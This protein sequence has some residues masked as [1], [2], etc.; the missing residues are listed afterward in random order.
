MI[1]PRMYRSRTQRNPKQ[2]KKPRNTPSLPL[3]SSSKTYSRAGRL[4]ALEEKLVEQSD[5]VFWAGDGVADGA[6]VHEDLV[7]VTTCARLSIKEEQGG[8]AG[9]GRMDRVG[10]TEDG[11]GGMNQEGRVESAGG[12]LGRSRRKVPREGKEGKRNKT[13]KTKIRSALGFCIYLL[14]PVMKGRRWELRNEERS[15]PCLRKS[16]S[17]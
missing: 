15:E 10:S 16:E 9:E 12:G 14:K 1:R 11:E 8:G 4:L 17:R 3:P 2:A 7:V 13:T 5:G 6:G